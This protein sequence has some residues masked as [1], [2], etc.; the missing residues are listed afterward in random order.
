MPR[1]IEPE[2]K[3]I[4]NAKVFSF[5]DLREILDKIR[6]KRL[7]S[8]S[9]AEAMIDV[10]AK[11]F[12]LSLRSRSVSDAVKK[13]RN[14]MVNVRDE[15]LAKS[16]QSLAQGEDPEMV[17]EKLAHQLTNK[18]LHAPSVN[19]KKAACQEDWILVHA[20]EKLWDI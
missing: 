12:I 7:S 1:N 2:I 18:F 4:D 9:A 6:D 14:K 19:L 3:K 17:L 16:R 13:Y 8:V 15:Y 20:V 11:Q 10:Q 5:D